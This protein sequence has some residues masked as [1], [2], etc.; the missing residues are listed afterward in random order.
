MTIYIEKR[1][2]TNFISPRKLDSFQ[3]AVIIFL[4][5]YSTSGRAKYIYLDKLHFLFDLL[6]CD[7]DFSSLPKFTIPP[8]NIDKELKNKVIVLVK[9]E[10]ICPSYDNNKVRYSLTE[11]GLKKFDELIEIEELSILSS[12]AE[13]LANTTTKTFERSKVIYNV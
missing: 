5:A 3:I 6:I 9:N 12:K 2:Y 8:W 13:V 1:P 4:I 7:Q 11:K 10:I